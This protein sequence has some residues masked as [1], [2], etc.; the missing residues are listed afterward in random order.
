[1]DQRSSASSGAMHVPW[2]HALGQ[3]RAPVE[4]RNR[5]AGLVFADHLLRI[6]DDAH[7]VLGVVALEKRVD[8]L[9]RLEHI[10][11]QLDFVS[12]DRK[13][14]RLNSSHLVISYAVFC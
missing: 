3:L 12:I 11:L 4:F 14:T 1:M 2:R 7:E 9:C 10:H 8:L 6:E 5:Y 13:S